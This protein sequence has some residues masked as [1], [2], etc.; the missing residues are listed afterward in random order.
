MTYARDFAIALSGG[1]TGLSLSAQVVDS[2][3]A[4]VGSAIT[5]G[6]AEIGSGNYLFHAAA[7]PANHRGGIKVYET[8]VPATV[9]A[10]VAVNPEDAE[11]VLSIKAKTDAIDVGPPL[12]VISVQN[13][14]TLTATRYVTF[15]H[16]LEHLAIP[17]DW[18]KGYFTV[19][20]DEND[21]DTASTL[22]IAVMASPAGT[23]GMLYL[24]KAAATDRTDGSLALDSTLG[25]ATITIADEA[26]GVISQGNYLWDIK[27]LRSGASASTQVA[28]GTF[29]M[30]TAITHGV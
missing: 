23:D 8:G 25:T 22:Q 11:Y 1:L 29:V 21:G 18:T 27:V 24:G 13:G 4:S 7:I 12:P 5:S 16:T 9:L 28:T 6:F 2:T 26:T 30:G 17:V 3:G 14:G 15:S 10:F 20:H 19:K